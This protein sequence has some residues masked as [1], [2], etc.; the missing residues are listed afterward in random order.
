M[1]ETTHNREQKLVD[2][3][4]DAQSAFW[5]DTYQQGMPLDSSID[6]G[7]LQRSSMSTN[8]RFQR[9]PMF[10]KSAAEQVSWQ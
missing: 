6:K 7:R 4:F 9:I 2:E 10:S 1:G 3:Y 8:C 5:R